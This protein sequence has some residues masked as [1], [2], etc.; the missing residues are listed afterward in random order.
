MKHANPSFSILRLKAAS[1]WTIRSTNS[2]D[3]KSF[4][5]LG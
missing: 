2:N 5:E 1:S 4:T 3:V